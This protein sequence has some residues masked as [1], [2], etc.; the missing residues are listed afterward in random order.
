M[1]SIRVE[2]TDLRATVVMLFLIGTFGLNFPISISTMAVNVFHSDARGFS[3]LS[4][5]MAVG[6]ISGA[7]VAASRQIA[8]MASLL[9]GAGVFGLGCTPAALAPA[10]WWLGVA[11]V[12]IGC[13]GLTFTNGTNSIMQL[14]TEP[15]MR[16]RVMA[17]RVGIALGGHPSVRRSSVGLPTTSAL[18]GR[19]HWVRGRASSLSASQSTFW[20]T[21]KSRCLPAISPAICLLFRMDCCLQGKPLINAEGI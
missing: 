14:S 7:L 2:E 17:L 21:Q 11:L 9:V 3:L 12:L 18:A 15:S 13:A 8:N 4:S 16:G 19:S 6:T 1:F 5:I 20:P 10:Y